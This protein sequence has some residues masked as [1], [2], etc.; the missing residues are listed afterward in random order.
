MMTRKQFFGSLVG[1]LGL[2][3]LGSACTKPLDDGR[4]GEGEGEGEGPDAGVEQSVSD[5]AVP[6]APP[7][8]MTCTSMSAVISSN[9]G[10]ALVVSAADVAAGL[11][12]TYNIKGTST[13]PHSV[14][15]TAAMFATLK[16]TKMLKV[17][18][19][20]DSSHSHSVTVTC[21]A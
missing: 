8:A 21:A 14:K 17:T 10:H 16:S 20:T 11:E 6:D 19:S 18:S 13:H 5:A 4:E 1:M 3:T 2:A 15:I 9:H 7:S 12:K